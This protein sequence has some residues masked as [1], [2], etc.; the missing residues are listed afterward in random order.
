MKLARCMHV[1]V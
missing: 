1:P